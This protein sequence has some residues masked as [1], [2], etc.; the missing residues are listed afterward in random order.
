VSIR[1]TIYF[2]RKAILIFFMKMLHCKTFLQH[3]LFIMLN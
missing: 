1:T 3:I 2:H